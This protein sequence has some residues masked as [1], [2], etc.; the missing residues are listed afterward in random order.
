MSD[1]D[2]KSAFK[3]FEAALDLTKKLVDWALLILGGS[4]ALLLGTSHAYPANFWLRL[5]YVL[6]PAGWIL[7]AASMNYGVRA[8][9]AYLALL[10]RADPAAAEKM[11]ERLTR[12]KQILAEDTYQQIRYLKAGLLVFALWLTVYLVWWLA[13]LD[14]QPAK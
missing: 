1:Q 2:E 9:R 13:G 5:V 12:A 11:E 10:F 14:L 3:P 7:L 8:Q 4:I 6:F